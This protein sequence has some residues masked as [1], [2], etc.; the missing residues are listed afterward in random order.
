MRPDI[1]VIGLVSYTVKERLFM[2]EALVAVCIGI[3]FGPVGANW[4]SVDAWTGGNEEASRQVVYEITRIIL[5]IQV[6]VTG[7]NLPKAY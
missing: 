5:G 2:S 1:C 6:L 7:I 3:A 4:I